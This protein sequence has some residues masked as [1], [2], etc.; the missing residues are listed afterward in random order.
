MFV[1]DRPSEGEAE[2]LALEAK[3]R[4]IREACRLRETTGRST[5][6]R[7]LHDVNS[8]VDIASA[9]C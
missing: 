1:N 6:R 8:E 4:E 2:I 9:G 5:V 7:L 3:L